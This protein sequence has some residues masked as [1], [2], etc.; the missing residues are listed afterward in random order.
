MR[1]SSENIGKVTSNKIDNQ[2]DISVVI[3]VYN[4]EKTIKRCIDSIVNQTYPVF[5][6]IV[7]DDGSIDRTLDIVQEEYGNIVTI[8]RQKHKGA[9]AARNAGIRAAKG[10]YIAFLDSDDEWLPN[11]IE[12]QVQAL[13]KNG[14]VVVCGDG[15]TQM[16]WEE[17]IPIVYQRTG[18]IKKNTRMGTRKLLRMNG[19]NGNIYGIVLERTLGD[20]D[21]LLASKK[22]LMDIG[23]LDEKVPSF[24]EWDVVI[25]LAKK[26]QFVYI[27]RPLYVYHLH[28]GEAI[29]KNPE[30][31]IDGKE[32]IIK[33]HA[34][35]IVRIH[36][37]H[38]LNMHYKNLFILAIKYRSKKA[39]VF[40]IEILR[41]NIL[42][43]IGKVRGMF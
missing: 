30:R 28:D 37:L 5:E 7:V 17:N 11:K 41:I 22:S 14:D 19:A 33:K 6:I 18:N 40:V 21:S 24:Q 35:E 20:F 27:K 2:Y 3:P 16:D 4:R 39:L 34:Q 38:G 23:L 32:Y 29:S 31:I 12:L 15:Y 8:I 10:V 13:Y 42:F 36:G 25:R 26:N 43:L 9:Q 1:N